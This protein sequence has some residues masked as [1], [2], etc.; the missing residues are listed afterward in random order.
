MLQSFTRLWY[1]YG[2]TRGGKNLQIYFHAAAKRQ[3]IIFWQY[4]LRNIHR[5][6]FKKGG[7]CALLIE[8]T[9]KKPRIFLRRETAWFFKFL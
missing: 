1:I 2:Q 5:L 6:L 8:V 4:K 9:R 3:Q 7:I